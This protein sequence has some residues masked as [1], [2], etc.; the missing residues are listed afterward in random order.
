M[1]RDGYIQIPENIEVRIEIFTILL[2]ID[3]TLLNVAIGNGF[4]IKEVLLDNIAYKEKIVMGDKSINHKYFLSQLKQTIEGKEKIS[5]MCIT[6][7]DKLY[8]PHP[9]INE[10][11]TISDKPFFDAEKEIYKES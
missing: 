5:F 8:F 6:K 9:N 7:E 4:Q 1:E 2:G 11:I 3:K 10:T